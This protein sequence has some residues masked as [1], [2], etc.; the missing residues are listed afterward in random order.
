[1]LC[2][3]FVALKMIICVADLSAFAF[4]VHVGYLTP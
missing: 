3:Y 2:V 4:R 1:M